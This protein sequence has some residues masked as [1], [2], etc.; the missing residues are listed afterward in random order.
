MDEEVKAATPDSGNVASLVSGPY[1]AYVM[2]LLLGIYII[3][4][5]DR[6]VVNILAEPIKQDLALA[7]WQLGLMGGLAFAI[8]YTFLGVPI[9]LLAERHCRPLIISIAIAV[10][11][12][13]TA[14][15]GLA[16]NFGQLVLAR[17]GVGVGEAGCTPP[18]HSLI[19]DYAPREKRSSALAFYGMGA[20]IGGLL[21]MAFGGL[22][23]D[24][25]GW[26]V[27]FFIA[28]A[29][30]LIFAALAFS[31]LKEP[32]KIL[33]AGQPQ[34]PANRVTI[35]DT[36]RVLASKPSFYWAVGGISI[37]AFIAIG[38]GLFMASF[39]LRNH[40]EAVAQYAQALGGLQS[41][42]FLG[43]TI[44]LISGTFG[45]LGMWT[46]GQL[47]DRFASKDLRWYMWGCA[48]AAVAF[49][50]PFVF[51]VTVDSF[52]LALA[53]MGVSSMIGTLHYGPAVGS[54]L[55]V[56][57]AH[58]RAPASAIHL[59][60]ANLIGLGLGPLAVGALSDYLAISMGAA[61]G[62][63]WAMVIASFFGIPAAVMFWMAART[64]R[65]NMET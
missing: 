60:I 42:G 9:A 24:A 64:L 17:I 57:P 55:S 27:A 21:G 22:V 13:C 43:L 25:Y 18:A 61:E 15:C 10:W 19:V 59:F 14:L 36:L 41:M 65:E 46:G 34:K 32:R 26:R 54:T 47:A 31:T 29:P 6:Q 51:V 48:I 62:L 37:K 50:P 3:N 7:D 8:L 53:V 44:G 28:G 1:R 52:P 49:I 30:G 4:F 38:Y 23:A 5:L 63:R 45:A 11:S 20:P 16:Q 40:G 56:V 33:A 35:R 39:F 12:G 58:M 2:C